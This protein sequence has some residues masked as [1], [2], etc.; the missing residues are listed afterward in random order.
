[1]LQRAV[2]RGDGV[3][4]QWSLLLGKV[5]EINRRRSGAGTSGTNTQMLNRARPVT[6]CS[7]D[8]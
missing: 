4:Q 2:M 5:M 7:C 8:A 3:F 1:M 6:G